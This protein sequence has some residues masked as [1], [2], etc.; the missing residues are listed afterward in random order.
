NRMSWWELTKRHKGKIIA[1]GAIIGGAVAISMGMN[2]KKMESPQD[3]AAVQ[4]RRHYVFDA[5]QSA[6]DE[7]IRELAPSIFRIVQGRF[8]V[9]ALTRQ[10]QEGNLTSERKIELWNELKM[11]VIGRLLCLSH[12]L[13][14]LTLTLKAQISILAADIVT[15]SS[16]SSGSNTWWSWIPPSMTSFIG[17]KGEMSAEERRRNDTARQV[18]LRAIE[19]FTQTGVLELAN[20]VEDVVKR[21]TKDVRLDEVR[22][23]EEVLSLLNSLSIKMDE[24]AAPLSAYVAPIEKDD[25]SRDSVTLLL[26]RLIVLLDGQQCRETNA[27]LGNFYLSTSTRS[28]SRGALATQL[29]SLSS[30]FTS[31]TRLGLDSPLENSLCSSDVHR[32]AIHAF[33][34]PS[35]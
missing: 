35:L 5:N 30:S 16:G 24:E 33:N 18:F 23:S 4:A 19:F 32:F 15:M 8:N 17:G 11:T 20:V 6:C 10:L 2:Q 21:E 25:T 34:A 31:L 13:S 12:A 28:I 7:S 1:G 27:K 22:D 9:E 29:S 3:E 26:R 14:L